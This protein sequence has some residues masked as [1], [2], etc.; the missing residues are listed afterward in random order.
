MPASER[1]PSAEPRLPDAR[2]AQAALERKIAVVMHDAPYPAL[3]HISC[4]LDDG[5]LTLQ[6]RVPSYYLKQIAQTLV[7]PLEGVR[8]IHNELDV[9]TTNAHPDRVVRPITGPVWERF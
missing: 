7:R 2:R 5:V 1:T 9:G 4:V 8:V 3:R 6:G